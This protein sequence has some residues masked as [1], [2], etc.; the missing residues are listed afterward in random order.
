MKKPRPV[1]AGLGWIIVGLRYSLARDSSP[2]PAV[3]GRKIYEELHR[4]PAH[5]RTLAPTP[6]EGKAPS[7]AG[8]NNGISGP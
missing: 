5:G 6:E 3:G 8:A 1:P 2:P 4:E 7:R